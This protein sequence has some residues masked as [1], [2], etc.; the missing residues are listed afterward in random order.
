MAHQL[1]FHVTLWSDDASLLTNLEEH[2]RKY[3]AQDS[4]IGGSDASLRLLTLATQLAHIVYD[5]RVIQLDVHS[6]DINWDDEPA[7]EWVINNTPNPEFQRII[8]ALVDNPKDGDYWKLY[9][10]ED[11]K[12]DTTTS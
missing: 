9:R 6:V 5:N 4:E 10:K 2:L 12:D 11:D 3:E 8:N 1:D 7:D